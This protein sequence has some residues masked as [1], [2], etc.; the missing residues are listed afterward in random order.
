[1]DPKGLN[2]LRK[3]DIYEKCISNVFI[4]GKIFQGT[5]FLNTFSEVF[6]TSTSSFVIFSTTKTQGFLHPFFADLF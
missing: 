4:L 2:V 3:Q 5:S 1:M 6:K